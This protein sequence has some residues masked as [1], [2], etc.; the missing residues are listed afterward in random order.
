M[1]FVNYITCLNKFCETTKKDMYIDSEVIKVQQKIIKAKSVNIQNKYIKIFN[2]LKLV[3]N[4]LKCII[5]NCKNELL[6]E[7][8][9]L[10]NSYNNKLKNKKNIPK[11]IIKSIQLF[12][13]I[14]SKKKLTKNDI[15]LLHIQLD[16]LY[17]YTSY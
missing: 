1:E 3:K 4:N 12:N 7:Y 9:S 15:E 5:T 14:I 16:N 10:F 2:N 6:E 8:K 11:I 13:K 17:Y